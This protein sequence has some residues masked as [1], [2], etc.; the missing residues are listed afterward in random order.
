MLKVL[1]KTAEDLTNEASLAF[2]LQSSN[3]AR[4]MIRS[5]AQR[6]RHL[7]VLEKTEGL[8]RFLRKPYH[9]LLNLGG[10]GVRVRVGGKAD[11]WMPPE[12]AGGSWEDHEPQ[13]VDVFAR[14]V[15]EHPTGVVLDVGSSVGIF[16]AIALFAAPSVEVIAFDP[17]LSSLAA[18]RRMCQHAK[19]ARLRLVHCFV[20]DISSEQ[21]AIDDAVRSTA[22]SLGRNDITGD[23]GTTRYVALHDRINNSVPIYRLDDLFHEKILLERP[24]LVK[25]DVEGAELKVLRGF[26]ASLQQVKPDLMLSVHPAAL[27]EYASSKEQVESFLQTLGYKI[28]VIAI[29]HEEHWWC[30]VRKQPE[31]EWTC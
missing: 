7:P 27:C 22:R 15:Q 6:V 3:R 18:A 11:V 24:V 25:C 10:R 13:T 17:D 26:A 12:F 14:W 5:V 20:A 28:E 30:E 19:G 2:E 16:S 29:D 8:W 9:K 31:D 21:K 1:Q 23:V 4:S